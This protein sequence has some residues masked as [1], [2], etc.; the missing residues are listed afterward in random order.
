M[1]TNELESERRHIADRTEPDSFLGIRF[2]SCLFV[3]EKRLP[4]NAPSSPTAAD[5][6]RWQRIQ[7]PIKRG[8]RKRAAWRRFVWSSWLGATVIANS[9][10]SESFDAPPWSRAWNPPGRQCPR[11]AHLD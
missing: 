5:H 6:G 7:R 2:H 3:V 8:V 1:N 9:S 11:R 4:P 10:S